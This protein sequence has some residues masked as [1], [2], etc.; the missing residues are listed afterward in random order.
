M[1]LAKKA[2]ESQNYQKM[3]QDAETIVQEIASGQLDLDSMVERISKG[4][5]LIEKMRLRLEETKL[6]IEK[7][8]EDNQPAQG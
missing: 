8:R 6:K 1:S 5:E 3:L 7:L 2:T 4:Y